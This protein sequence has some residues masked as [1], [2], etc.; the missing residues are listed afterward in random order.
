MAIEILLRRSIDGVGRVGEVVSVKNGYARNCLIP[1][2][3]ASLVT[4]DAVRRIH[5]DKGIEAIREAEEA[6][7]RQELADKLQELTLTI[8]ARAGE[9]GHL[10]GSVGPRVVMDGLGKL[11]YPFDIRQIRFEPVRELGEY[12]APIALKHDHI[13]N[14]KVWVVQD[15][16]EAA[17]MAAER[18]EAEARGELE[19]APE[20]DGD[21]ASAEA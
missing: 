8:E 7:Y 6:K 20:Q 14:V 2:G 1:R 15:A 5:K 16:R 11:G 18:A 10:Y 13:V 4:A 17:E 3:W 9:D 21:E 19:P 12:E